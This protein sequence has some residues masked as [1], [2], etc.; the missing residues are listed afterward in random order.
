MS[1]ANVRLEMLMSQ[2]SVSTSESSLTRTLHA[3]SLKLG[4]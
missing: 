2:S 1:S 3:N 4:F